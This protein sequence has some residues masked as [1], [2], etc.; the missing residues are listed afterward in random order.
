MIRHVVMWRFKEFSEGK[1]K[2]ENMEI[3]RERL[4]ALMPIIHEIKRMEIG[5]DVSQTDASMDFMLLTE[6][7]T[8]D[9][10][11]IYADHP[12]HLKVS[13]YVRRV[14]EERVAVDCEI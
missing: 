2:V 3:V 13:S 6:F 1:S 14:T 12:E 9:A 4:Y 7:D 5:V 8:L 11:K 10:L